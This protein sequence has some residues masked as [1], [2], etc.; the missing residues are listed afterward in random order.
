MKR[1]SSAGGKPHQTPASIWRHCF[2][3]CCNIIIGI[4]FNTVSVLNWSLLVTEVLSDLIEVSLFT[5][6][7]KGFSF[8]HSFLF[9]SY[10][11]GR[12]MFNDAGWYPLALVPFL[13]PEWHCR[14]IGSKLLKPFLVEESE[15][16]EK[17]AL[18]WL[19]C[20]LEVV[21]GILTNLIKMAIAMQHRWHSTLFE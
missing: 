4:S 9:V 1:K 12:S 16:T 11:L 13:P 5:H 20:T 10:T 14:V 21:C 2:S 7:T 17:R 18:H 8:L 3:R 15:E 6:T 19:E